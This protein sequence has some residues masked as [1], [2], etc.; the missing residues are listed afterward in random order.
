[1]IWALPVESQHW[2]HVKTVLT[3]SE[4]IKTFAEVQ[5]CIKMEEECLKM[6]GTHHVALVAKGNR[7]KGNKN[8]Q[9]RQVK[10]GFR[11]PQNGRPRLGLPRSTRPKVMERSI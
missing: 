2:N 6:L 8:N 1:M 7:P 4:D 11:P 3:H 9:G 5:S 10:K